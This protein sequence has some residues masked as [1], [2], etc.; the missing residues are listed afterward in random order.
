M[1]VILRSKLGFEASSRGDRP[2]PGVAISIGLLLE[3][4]MPVMLTS[5]SVRHDNDAF[6]ANPRMEQDGTE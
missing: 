2:E 4:E 6:F 1:G 3:V 5:P